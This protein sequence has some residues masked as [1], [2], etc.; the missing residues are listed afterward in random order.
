MLCRPFID[1]IACLRPEEVRHGDSLELQ[2]IH[3]NHV[4]YEKLEVINNNKMIW[5]VLIEAQTSHC[6]VPPLV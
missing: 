3:S 2:S 4:K 5:N 1:F 6:V